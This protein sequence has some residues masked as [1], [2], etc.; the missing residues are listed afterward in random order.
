MYDAEGGP[1]LANSSVLVLPVAC[2]PGTV[3]TFCI[4]ICCRVCSFSLSRRRLT[5]SYSVLGNGVGAGTVYWTV[6]GVRAE[7]PIKIQ[8]PD[9]SSLEN[10]S[11]FSTEDALFQ[12]LLFSCHQCL[13]RFRSPSHVLSR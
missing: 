3:R 8:V 10:P 11:S 9:N 12:Q 7:V 6:L 1:S 4:L 2:L 5:H 13:D